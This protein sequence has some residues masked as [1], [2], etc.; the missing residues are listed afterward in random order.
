MCSQASRRDDDPTV[1]INA[2]SVGL[3]GPRSRL[4]RVLNRAARL[5]LA[6]AVFIPMALQPSLA[7]P[8]PKFNPMPAHQYE[9]VATIQ[10]A[11]GPFDEVTG[12][13]S[14]QVS[15]T[16][17]LPLQPGSG[18]TLA[19]Q[20]RL[21][22]KLLPFSDGYTATFHLDALADAN[23]FG[24]GVCHWDIGGVG[25]NL[26]VHNV[27][28]SPGLSTA[29]VTTRSPITT[30]FARAAYRNPERSGS[31]IGTARSAYVTSHPAEFFA[32]TLQS[33]EKP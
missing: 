20:R 3:E 11:P 31:T 4:T 8:T 13:V 22:L 7:S 15:N 14:Y 27:V 29:E 9:L 17:C 16:D 33:K 12:Y 2:R 6:I 10:D 30:Y 1:L 18:A 21:P 23:Y 32:V 25:L 24:L 28:F 5:M 26:T 19:M